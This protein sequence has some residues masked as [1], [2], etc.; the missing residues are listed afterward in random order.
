MI[1][2][3]A[4]VPFIQFWRMIRTAKKIFWDCGFRIPK[5]NTFGCK[6]EGEIKS[7]GVEE[8]GFMCMDGVSGLEDGAKAIFPNVVVQCCTLIRNSLK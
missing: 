4:I 5:A 3:A 1:T 6:F 8:V 2:K 7:R